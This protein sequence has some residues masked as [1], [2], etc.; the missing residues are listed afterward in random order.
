MIAASLIAI[1]SFAQNKM[2]V[3]QTD[4]RLK[5]GAVSTMKDVAI[6]CMWL[7]IKN[8]IK[9]NIKNT[10]ALCLSAIHLAAWQKASHYCT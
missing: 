7:F 6:N 5:D 4:F 9:N 10:K 8:N 1:F 3:Y 2:V